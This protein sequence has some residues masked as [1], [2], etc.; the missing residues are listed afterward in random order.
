MDKAT[1]G[2]EKLHVYRSALEFVAL[3]AELVAHLKVEHRNARDQLIRS[4]QSV[5][6]N[7]ADDVERPLKPRLLHRYCR[8]FS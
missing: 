2:H 5:P 6:L 1:F 8:D 4:S 3:T 7:I